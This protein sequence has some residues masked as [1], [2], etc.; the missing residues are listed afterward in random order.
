MEATI[1]LTLHGGEEVIFEK[2]DVR[3][4]E[5]ISNGSKVTLIHGEQHLV[6]EDPTTILELLKHRSEQ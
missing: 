2:P 4:I 3:V 1:A 6:N 5:R